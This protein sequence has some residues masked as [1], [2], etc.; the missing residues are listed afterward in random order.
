[1]SYLCRSA[2]LSQNQKNEKS[3]YGRYTLMPIPSGGPRKN[4]HFLS[5]YGKVMVAFLQGHQK[6]LSLS[7][8]VGK[9]GGRT[10]RPC[11]FAMG[12]HQ[13]CYVL[14]CFSMFL[15][16]GPPLKTTKYCKKHRKTGHNVAKYCLFIA[17]HK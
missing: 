4:F 17:I 9:S 8:N 13:K 3:K 11:I 15:D 5:T 14:A 6:K 7:L 16:V 2:Y 12:T 10:L 1:M